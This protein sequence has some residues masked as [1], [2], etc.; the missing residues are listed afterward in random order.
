MKTGLTLAQLTEELKTNKLM[1]EGTPIMGASF[2]LVKIE[3]KLFP[4][5]MS[6]LFGEM[7]GINFFKADSDEKG[8][9]TG[10]IADYAELE[11][12]DDEVNTVLSEIQVA[13][14]STLAELSA[15]N[16]G[17][18]PFNVPAEGIL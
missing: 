11:L 16:G 2:M 3:D 13:V 18:L 8:F 10:D 1:L 6:L 7:D 4:V 17:V 14:P 9:A 5:A 15:M 12:D